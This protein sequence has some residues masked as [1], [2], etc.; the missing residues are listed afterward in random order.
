M[1][2]LLSKLL[3]YISRVHDAM[4]MMR[5]KNTLTCAASLL[6]GWAW[7]YPPVYD[8]SPVLR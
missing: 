4:R 2:P 6:S 7:P 5:E 1:S 8:Q 3:L